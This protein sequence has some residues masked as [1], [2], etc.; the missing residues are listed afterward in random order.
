MDGAAS[1][2]VADERSGVLGRELSPREEE[3]HAELVPAANIKEL[4]AWEKF[5]VCEALKAD[6]PSRQIA[7]TRWV[8]TW[9]MVDAQNSVE[10]RLVAQGYQDPDLQ[11]GS[12][13]T[14]GC[15][16]L[17]SSHLQVISLCAI[18]TWKMRSPDIKNAFLQA[19]GLKMEV[20]L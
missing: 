20:F 4:K 12:V 9:K 11:D 3:Q 6:N 13:D 7:Q 10:A 19:D 14:S 18:K 5:D 16:T 2:W 1:A 15:V 17:R 8:L